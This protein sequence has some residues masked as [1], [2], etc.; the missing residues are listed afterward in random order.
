MLLRFASIS[1]LDKISRLHQKC[2]RN[3]EKGFMYRL[4]YPFF[5]LYYR[6]MLNEKNCV[7]LCAFNKKNNN[8]IGFVSGSLDESEHIENL[9]RKKIYLLLPALH[10]IIKDP[11]L[12]G[13]IYKRSKFDNLNQNDNG[14]IITEGA[15][16]EYWGWDP[17]EKEIMGAVELLKKWLDIMKILGCKTIAHEVDNDNKKSIKLHS[18]LGSKVIRELETP[19]GKLRSIMEYRFNME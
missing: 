8:L 18:I 16:L 1:D 19:G 7:I 14:Y 3:Q 6:I 12:I 9:K 17:E 10:A 4:G 5:K 11:K 15:R 2:S 13:E